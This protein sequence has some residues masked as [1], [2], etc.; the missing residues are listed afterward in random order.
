MNYGGLTSVP[1]HSLLTQQRKSVTRGEGGARDAD[2]APTQATNSICS[3][4]RTPTAPAPGEDTADQPRRRDDTQGR[5]N[6]NRV[7][8]RHITLKLPKTSREENTLNAEETT[9]WQS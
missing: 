7:K 8:L 9:S 4:A 1:R 5:V 3:E 6:L 2:W